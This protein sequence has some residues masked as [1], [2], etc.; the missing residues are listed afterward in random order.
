MTSQ[1]FL[2]HFL[3]NFRLGCWAENG[4]H[5]SLWLYQNIRI[6]T[7]SLGGVLDTFVPSPFPPFS[8]KQFVDPPQ[9][10]SHFLYSAHYEM[11][12]DLSSTIVSKSHC[13]VFTWFIVHLKISI[14]SIFSVYSSVQ[15][16]SA[17]IRASRRIY[18]EKD[19]CEL[20]TRR[21]RDITQRVNPEK[22]ALEKG[23]LFWKRVSVCMWWGGVEVGRNP[24]KCRRRI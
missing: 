13:C 23:V 10:I 19:V 7:Y 16:D 6:S 3:T 18:C 17:L 1:Q 8:P 5:R 20:C 4:I 14:L 12:L 21:M 11:L 22:T 24:R 15:D 2:R 9:K